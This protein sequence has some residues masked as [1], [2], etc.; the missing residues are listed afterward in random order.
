MSTP[1]I[2]ANAPIPF[3]A[4]DPVFASGGVKRRSVPFEDGE[5]VVIVTTAT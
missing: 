1:S 4:V 5:R 3:P 2:P